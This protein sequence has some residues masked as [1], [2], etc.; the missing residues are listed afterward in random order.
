M[1]RREPIPSKTD[2]R[3]KLLSTIPGVERRLELDGISTA[4]LEA[5]EGPPVVILHGPSGNAT[6]WMRVIPEL[7]R[8]HRVIVPEL[9]GHGASRLP[10]GPLDEQRVLGWLAAVVEK[11]CDSPPALVGQL[12]GGA[13]AARA[14][15]AGQRFTRLVLI[16]AF[17]LCDFAPAPEL[18]SA[19]TRFGMA[20]AKDTHEELWKF[21]ARDFPA[22]RRDMGP[23]WN[24]FEA[25]NIERASSPEQ[26][27][28]LQALMLAF[29]VRAI[30]DAELEKIEL[31]T[32]LLWGRHDLATPLAVA[33]KASA[34][35]HWPLYV[36]AGANDDP[37][38]ER[39]HVVRQLL[40]VALND[41][42]E[43]CAGG[44]A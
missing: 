36:I 20:P 13:I 43:L 17:G 37:P 33:Q 16:D 28:A 32:T 6:H 9:P 5:G 22:L 25:Y 10:D 26:G 4:V 34:R 1:N 18:G 21:C 14:A 3:A 38:I 7:S 40:C 30:P 35:H 15:I 19:L 8:T 23:L 29:G 24:A 44:N 2:A 11:T 42:I 12:L 27:A 41:E 39:P 31:P